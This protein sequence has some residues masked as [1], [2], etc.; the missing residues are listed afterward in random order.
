MSKT[1]LLFPGQ[2]SQYVGMGKD[3]YDK[4]PSSRAIFETADAILCF[5]LTELMFNGDEEEL[6]KTVHAQPALMTMS[7]ACLEA[8][9]EVGVL[10]A[11]SVM[12]G[13]S[14][15]EY[16]ALTAAGYLY[17]PDALRL[18]RE[19]GRLMFEAGMETPGTM[20]AVIAMEQP[21]LQQVCEETGC[22]I[23][24]LNCPGQIAI[25]G[26]RE[27]VLTAS[28]L[29][30]Q[31]GAKLAIPLQVSGAFHCPLISS[32]ADGLR[33]FIQKLEVKVPQIPVVGNTTALPLDNTDGVRKELAEQ[34]CSC[35]RW[36]ESVRYMLS[37]GIDTF[38]EVGPGRVLTGLVKRIDPSVTTVNIGSVQDID[39]L[40]AA[41]V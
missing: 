35:V 1:A 7:M 37:Q 28:K 31:R 13:H 4:F 27:A 3:L 14:L 30:R 38:V 10:P 6:K 34:V 39:N 5:P 26:T 9:K 18:A 25:S 32:A 15:G 8:A 2:G 40:I 21:A 29:A 23:A 17:F 16:S 19:R 20:A 12:A 36:E 22:F 24:N 33:P 11:A 41:S